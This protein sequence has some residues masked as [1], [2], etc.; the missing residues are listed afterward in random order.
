MEIG[1]MISFYRKYQSLTQGE[2]AQGICSQGEISL[3]EKGLRVPSVEMVNKISTRLGISIEVFEKKSF[4]EKHEFYINTV[5]NKLELLVNNR[6]YAKMKPYLNDEILQNHCT[7]PLTKQCFL[8]Y[9]GIYTSYGV[10]QPRKALEIYRQALQETN[11]TAF[12]DISDFPKH[13]EIY[14]KTETLLISGAASC[15]YLLKDFQKA[16]ILFKVASQNI[17]NIEMQ[18]STQIL[19]TIYY[20]ACKNLKALKKYPQAIEIAQDGLRFET[21]RKTI[22]RSAEI[23]YELGDIYY[24]QNQLELAEKYYIKSMYLSYSTNSTHFLPLLLTSLRKKTNLKL[25]QKNLVMLD[26]INLKNS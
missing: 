14:S 16:E 7:N 15:Y 18:L 2:L 3:I 21:N 6:D 24:Q 25:L 13:K 11:V 20:N 12:S 10:K 19:G 9:R 5:L 22:Y 1:S 23:L 4:Y 8:C 26:L 17:S